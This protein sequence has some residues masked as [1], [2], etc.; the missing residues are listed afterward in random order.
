M[1]ELVAGK[2]EDFKRIVVQI[3]TPTANGTGF[4]IKNKNLIITNEHVIRGYREVVVS[5]RGI[6]KTVSEVLYSDKMHD[7]A[8]LSF[9]V[10]KEMPQIDL[11]DSDVSLETGSRVVAIGHPYGLSF[12]TTEGIISK[13]RRLYNNINYI[14]FDAAMNPGNSGG[15]LVNQSGKVI[16]VNTFII[17]GGN[18]LGFALPVDLLR[19]SLADYDKYSGG[20]VLRCS[21][22]TNLVRLEELESGYCP[23]CGVKMKV[24]KKEEY[25]PAGTAKLVEDI[26]REIVPDVKLTRR[27]AYRWEVIEGSAK[28]QFNYSDNTGFIV[29]DAQLAR[30][31]RR[32]IGELYEFLL[33]ENDSMEGLSFSVHHQDIILSLMIYDQYLRKE[34]GVRLFKHLLERADYYDNVLVEKFGALW[35]EEES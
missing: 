19:L 4:Y 34:T 5:G 27:G 9:P 14:Q 10:S 22:C 30:I 20:Q 33:R 21:S 17:E 25:Q 35:K 31:P 18:N 12:T 32:K 16:G 23:N 13:G 15:P 3:S 29:G 28:V 11:A 6:D 26:L 2:I 8:F 7:L 1:S 24:A